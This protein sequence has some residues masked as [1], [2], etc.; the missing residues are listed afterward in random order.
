MPCDH[1]LDPFTIPV[2]LHH[3]LEFP[4]LL[5]L[6]PRET[7]LKSRRL[8]FNAEVASVKSIGC[9]IPC[10]SSWSQMPLCII[11]FVCLCWTFSTVQTDPL[12]SMPKPELTT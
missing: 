4:K 10:G 11:L 2:L 8:N 5:P 7:C 12:I 9:K 3:D 6:L 1:S